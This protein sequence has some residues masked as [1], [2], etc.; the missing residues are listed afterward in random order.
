[1]KKQGEFLFETFEEALEFIDNPTN[2]EREKGIYI[3]Y[4][5]TI[6]N[7]P[8]IKVLLV[9]KSDNTDTMFIFFK[10]SLKY[11]VWKFWCPSEKQMDIVPQLVE[12][13]SLINN[14]NK[15]NKKIGGYS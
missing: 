9:H 2:Y 4:H 3:E 1:M 7:E 12:I 13:Y 8:E 6:L 15:N 11:D 14:Q 5:K 10:N